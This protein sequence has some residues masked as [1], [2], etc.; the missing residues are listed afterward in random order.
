M[1]R[2][3]EVLLATY[4][5]ENYLRSFLDSVSKQNSG[6]HSIKVRDDGSTDATREILLEYQK[7]LPIE[8]KLNEN[9]LGAKATFLQ[10]MQ[11]AN[12]DITLFADQDDIWLPNKVRKAVTALN[13]CGAEPAMYQSNLEV[14]W[15]NTNFTSTFNKMNAFEGNSQFDFKRQVFTNRFTGCAMAINRDLREKVRFPEC[16]SAIIM[17]DWWIGLYA[18]AFAAVILDKSLTIRYR[19]HSQNDTGVKKY[20]TY[21]SLLSYTKGRSSFQRNFEKSLKQLNAFCG[22][23][24]QNLK[25]DCAQVAKELLHIYEGSSWP[26]RK[27][28]LMRNYRKPRW[29]STLSG[30]VRA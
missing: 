29:V 4:N 27:I 14:F 12:S 8:V 28:L 21:G 10:L 17:H 15:E 18:T 6:I 2:S 3:V 23:E 19:Q 9:N 11:D 5:G 16:K 30:I 1:N 13:E 25:P 26:M 7:H 22:L 20:S 24:A